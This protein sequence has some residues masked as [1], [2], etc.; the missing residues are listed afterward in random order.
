MTSSKQSRRA[1][2]LTSSLALS[3]LLFVSAL[4]LGALIHL[5]LPVARRLVVTHVNAALAGTTAG[6]VEIERVGR[7]G[8]DGVDGLRARVRDRDGMQVLFIDGLHVRIGTLDLLR[9]ALRSEGPIVVHLASLA[10]D[11][12][13]VD[14]DMSSR[15]DLVLARALTPRK[16]SPSPHD[17]RP[18]RAIVIDAPDVR[19]GHAWVHGMLPDAPPIDV[20]LAALAG[21]VHV[22]TGVPQVRVEVDHARIVA[23][24]LPHRMDPRGT[25]RGVLATPAA[26]GHGIDLHARFGGEIGGIATTLEGSMN[27]QRFAARLDAEDQRGELAAREPILLHAEARGQLPRGEVRATLR[28]GSG[29]IDADATVTAGATTHVKGKLRA[30]DVDAGAIAAGAPQTRLGLDA[31]ADLTLRHDG[32]HGEVALDT[33]PGTVDRQGVPRVTMRG[34]LAGAGAR[35]TAR[36]HDPAMPTEVTVVL[37]P[38]PH[39]GRIMTASLRSRIPELRHIAALGG[40]IGGAAQIDASARLLLPEAYLET[41]SARIAIGQLESKHVDLDTV[42]IGARASGPLDRPVID[43]ELHGR[44]LVGALV[45]IAKIDG[46]TRAELRD[47]RTTLRRTTLRIDRLGDER[48][49][50][51]GVTPRVEVTTPLVELG[52]PELRIHDALV[53]GLG[54]PIHADVSRDRHELRALIDA[55]RI[56]LPSV[57]DLINIKELSI[58]K[59]TLRARVNAV[60]RDGIA[61]GTAHAEL[62]SLTTPSLKDAKGMLDASIDDRDAAL[63]LN[64]DLGGAGN[65]DLAT[66]RLHIVGSP[67]DLRSWRRADGRIAISGMVNMDHAVTTDLAAALPVADVHGRLSFR[68]TLGRDSPAAPPELELHAYT[69]GLALAGRSGP[70]SSTVSG[71]TVEAPP[72]WR[73]SGVDLGLDVRTDGPSGLA[74]VAG[75]AT[76]RR[77]ALVTLSAKAIVPFARVAGAP[78]AAHAWGLLEEAPMNVRV[79]VPTRAVAEL[80]QIAGIRGARG[81]FDVDV[82]G[83]GSLMEPRIRALARSRG[84]HTIAM[85]P[86]IDAD[87]DLVLDYDGKT[88]KVAATVSSHGRELATADARIDARMGDLIDARTA[89]PWTASAKAKL[90]SF[91]LETIPQLADRRI[92]GRAS[93]ELSLDGLHADARARGRIDLDGFAIG[94]VEYE[95]ASLSADTTN[96]RLTAR[97]RLDQKDGFADAKADAGVEWGA[98]ITPK[99]DREQPIH[100]SLDASAFRAAV[101]EPI[102]EDWVPAIDGRIDANARVHLVPGNPQAEVEGK[103]ALRDGTLQV[104]ALGEELRGVRATA[105]L[106]PDGTVRITD[107][108]ARG[109]QGAVYGDGVVK[110]DGLRVADATVNLRIPDRRPLSVAVEGR[111]IGEVSGAMRINASQTPDT[112]GTHVVVEISKLDVT[113]PQTSKRGLQSLTQRKNVRVGVYRDP[114]KFV[115][116]PLEAKDL[117]RTKSE[118]KS[119][120]SRVEIDVRLGRIR[121]ARANRLRAELSGNPKVTI[122]NGQTTLT[123]S[124]DLPR[125]WIDVQGKK[126]E[127]EKGTITFNGEDPPDPTVVATAGWTAQDGTRVYADFIGPASTGRVTL[128]SEPPR[129]QNEI[130]AIVLFGTAD[131]SNPQPAAAGAQSDGTTKA[132]VGLGGGLVAQGLT[133]ALEDLAGIQ[134]TARVDTTRANNPRPEIEI[135]LSSKVSL[136]FSHVLGTPPIAEPDKNFASLEYRFHRNWSLE[137]TFGDRGTALLDAIWQKRY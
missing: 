39:E 135:Q 128:R 47:G 35:I 99:L 74:V 52:G 108:A 117:Q 2:V 89:L 131:G 103:V 101:L 114:H 120:E 42:E 54:D 38:R 7:L 134:A 3:L 88:A 40:T 61:R 27:D 80:P 50:D 102:V 121:L 68:G 81:N 56:D 118:V 104:A 64:A 19:F 36:V 71:V 24:G 43:A 84:V 78:S 112:R 18:S 30:R 13:D 4:V 53:V 83:S 127:I 20:D 65:I 129:P 59:G 70:P 17:E 126:F 1:L 32:V 123:G 90:A 94:D 60:I 86:D 82:V 26:S 25:L 21:G 109:T 97:A 124:I 133:E 73:L 63:V 8:L 122:E 6:S 91:P 79:T 76:D 12:A 110:L 31:E 48:V 137:T 28:A 113:L 136:S 95:R 130:L 100:A 23:R 41:S 46:S 62:A 37:H 72:S 119:E 107:V 10:I 75:R 16:E 116:L 49:G 67:A 125:G 55:P 44:Q 66:Q 93:G 57:A 11:S 92:R 111:P 9:T 85:P 98:A 87:T 58:S 115:M 5:D 96:G 69:T 45:P 22:E 106:A 51:R 34:R 33:L 77:G 105:A 29:L 132:A 14:L 15:G